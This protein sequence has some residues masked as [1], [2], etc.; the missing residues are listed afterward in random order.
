MLIQSRKKNAKKAIRKIFVL[1]SHGSIN[2]KKK[3]KSYLLI[4]NRPYE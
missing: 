4:V 1:F 2:T 3:K